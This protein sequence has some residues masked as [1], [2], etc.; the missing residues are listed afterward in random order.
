[1]YKI[2]NSQGLGVAGKQN[3]LIELALT[4]GFDGVEVDMTDLIGRHDTLGKQFACQFLQSAKIDMGTFKLPID[5]GASDEKYT[6]SIAKLDTI[7]DLATTLNARSCYVEI[8]PNN[9][10]FSFQENF[11]KHQSRLQELS[12]KFGDLKIGLF[13][14]ASNQKPVDGEFKFIQTADE[15]LTLVKAVGQPNVGVCLDA[16]EWVVGGGTV[17]QLTT[18]GIKETV[19]EIRLADVAE[20]ANVAEIKSSERTSLPGCEA[21]SFSVAL[22]KAISAS[23]ADITISV[24]T[25]LST[26]SEGSRDNVVSQLS[27]QLDLLIAG[28]DPFAIKQAEAAA[29]EASEAEAEKVAAAAE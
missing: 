6:E 8:I 17:E 23:D 4:H 21:N 18:A 3:E 22:C 7:L 26:F 5:L 13:L 20:G 15:L 10:E 29:A 9:G 14:K 19:T 28:E 12:E 11:E 16:W 24:A 2:L 25:D 1:M 27:K